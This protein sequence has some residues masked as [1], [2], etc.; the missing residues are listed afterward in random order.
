[1][2]VGFQHL[3]LLRHVQTHDNVA[4]GGLLTHACALL[5]FNASEYPAALERLYESTPDECLPQFYT[6]ARVGRGC[7][8]QP[9]QGPE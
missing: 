6:D 3:L 1:M 9:A 5:Q 4:L 7:I 8:L 2:L